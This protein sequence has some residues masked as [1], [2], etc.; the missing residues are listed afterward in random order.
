MNWLLPIIMGTTAFAYVHSFNRVMKA[1][2]DSQYTMTWA[3]FGQSLLLPNESS[4]DA[5][6]SS[7]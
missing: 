3:Q 2:K 4:Q 6:Y 5:F 1:Y 7:K